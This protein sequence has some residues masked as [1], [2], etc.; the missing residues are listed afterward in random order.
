[1]QRKTRTHHKVQHQ[2]LEF[3]NYNFRVG[4]LWGNGSD[5]IV[6]SDIYS[7]VSGF[8]EWVEVRY[9]RIDDLEIEYVSERMVYYI[10]KNKFV[11]IQ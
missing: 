6:I 9:R 1:M 2:N 5:V 8:N 3:G 4:D 7:H 11:P 10:I